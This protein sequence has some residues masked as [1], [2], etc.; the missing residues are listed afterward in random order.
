M[1]VYVDDRT[2][3]TPSE[4]SIWASVI[5][6]QAEEEQQEP[7]V[8]TTVNDPGT[9]TQDEQNETISK[10]SGE[11]TLRQPIFS[12]K[13]SNESEQSNAPAV[14]ETLKTKIESHIETIFTAKIQAQVETYFAEWK[15]ERQSEIRS[16]IVTAISKLQP[17]TSDELEAC[18]LYTSPSPRDA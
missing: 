13:G 7:P 14:E 9:S 10:P 3:Q 12:D 17:V 8:V 1:K 16:Q 2:E 6:R 11:P 18:L 5:K 15:S 4:T